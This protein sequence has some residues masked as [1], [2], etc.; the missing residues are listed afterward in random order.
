MPSIEYADDPRD[1]RNFAI[2][3]WVM[4]AGFL[5]LLFWMLDGTNADFP[6]T[7]LAAVLLA[8]VVAGTVAAERAWRSVTPLRA[9]TSGHEVRAVAVGQF[10][11]LTIRKLIFCETPLL[12]AVIVAFVSSYAGWPLVIAGF[13]GL[14]VLAW[15][16]WPSLR[17]T[18]MAAAMLDAAGAESGLIESFMHP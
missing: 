3:Q 15:E 14:L 8:L 11:K 13:P 6:P 1:L 2:V 9:N 10:A 16:T 18:S 17:N 5:A 12:I 7:W 4:T